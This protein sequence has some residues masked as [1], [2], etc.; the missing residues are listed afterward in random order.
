ML[1]CHLK[2]KFEPNQKLPLQDGDKLYKVIG[3]LKDKDMAMLEER[4][5]RQAK[6][7]PLPGTA[8]QQQ[9][10]QQQ[11]QDPV[12]HRRP[13]PDEQPASAGPQR[14]GFNSAPRRPATAG[15]VPADGP[16][17]PT[18]ARGGGGHNPSP[19]KM[20]PVS[21]AFTLDL[22]KIES[23]VD[24]IGDSGLRLVNHKLDDIFNDDPVSLPRTVSGRR[25]MQGNRGG[26]LHNL[27]SPPGRSAGDPASPPESERPLTDMPE[28][29]EALDV[30]L[31]QIFNQVSD[32]TLQ[33]LYYWPYSKEQS[34]NLI[35]EL[36]DN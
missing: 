29:Y 33:Y 13:S 27:G 21:G 10:Q 25:A 17:P 22:D 36:L 26:G 14:R 8:A 24:N 2:C 32:V 1:S 3:N 16:P 23:A 5:K 28:A 34:C 12:Q 31:A 4:I 6:T 9:Q 35:M 30:V 15:G 19:S 11:Q 18:A 7:R 20:R